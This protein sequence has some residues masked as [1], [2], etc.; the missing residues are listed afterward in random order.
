[1]EAALASE[2]SVSYHNTTRCH[3]PECFDLKP[4]K[5]VDIEINSGKAKWIFMSRRHKDG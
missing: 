4:S 5:Y 2:T 1:M 3:N